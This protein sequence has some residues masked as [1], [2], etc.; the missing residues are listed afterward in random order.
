MTCT[1]GHHHN[2]PPDLR[3]RAVAGG[4]PWPVTWTRYG[5]RSRRRPR[6]RSTRRGRRRCC[7]T[8]HWG[9]RQIRRSQRILIV[10]LR[11]KPRGVARCFRAC[12]SPNQAQATPTP[13]RPPT[14][15]RA[16]RPVVRNNP[17]TRYKPR[18]R[19]VM[20]G[21]TNCRMRPRPTKTPTTKNSS[22][23][24]PRYLRSSPLIRSK[25]K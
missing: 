9:C 24:T 16:A 11:A 25:K 2:R 10:L 17:K 20:R 3:R 12:L 7:E 13:N 21:A 22:Q 8:R 15:S 5:R 18:R 23:S 19:R 14:Q 1:S 4:T 6:R